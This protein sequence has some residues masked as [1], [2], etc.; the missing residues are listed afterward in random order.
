MHIEES[1]WAVAPA[2]DQAGESRSL[3]FLGMSRNRSEEKGL[4]VRLELVPNAEATTFEL[5]AT[6][7][8]EQPGQALKKS[9]IPGN[10]VNQPGE[11]KAF[12]QLQQ[13]ATVQ[14]VKGDL[15]LVQSVQNP[16]DSTRTAVR[17]VRFKAADNS[18]LG[19]GIL[20]DPSLS[21]LQPSIAVD[22]AGN[23]VIGA[24]GTSKDQFLSAYV[25]TGRV[26]G[27]TV[28]FDPAFT[29]VKAGAGIHTKNNRW[30]DYTTTVVD[31]SVPGRFWTFLV[32]ADANGD[33]ASQ[34]AE[35]ILPAR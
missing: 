16:S 14:R 13:P 5:K 15:W 33:W 18:V 4:F 12:T 22:P 11:G 24:G 35:I 29:L 10:T 23:I 34:I 32:Y 19:E 7:I 30:G 17:W 9:G 3:T 21:L 26:K 1:R 6:H 27:E 31:P 8:G 25:T 20:A 28:T 2:V